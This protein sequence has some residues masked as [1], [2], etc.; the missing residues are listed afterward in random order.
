M[1]ADVTTT[2]DEIGV[3]AM[4]DATE[5]EGKKDMAIFILNKPD[6]EKPYTSQT[7]INCKKMFY[8]ISFLKS[9]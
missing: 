7:A 8:K 5:A 1:D 6:K 3:G 9:F 4:V 2:A